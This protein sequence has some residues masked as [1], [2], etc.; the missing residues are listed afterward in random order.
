[1]KQKKRS[2]KNVHQPA[3]LH[4]LVSTASHVFSQQGI[5]LGGAIGLIQPYA[6]TWLSEQ[7][8]E[9]KTATISARVIG[10]QDLDIQV[11]IKF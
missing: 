7:N 6:P 10:K 5:F 9:A 8:A 2:L 4:R 11:E 3:S 1:M